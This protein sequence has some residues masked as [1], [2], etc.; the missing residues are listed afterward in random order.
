MHFLERLLSVNS[1]SF[2]CLQGI[3][4]PVKA[5]VTQALWCLSYSLTKDPWC[6]TVCLA[7]TQT[8]PQGL[9]H[10][11]RQW[12]Q[13]EKLDSVHWALQYIGTL[14]IITRSQSSLFMIINCQ[15]A[16]LWIILQ[17]CVIKRQSKRVKCQLKSQAQK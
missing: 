7:F 6:C 4:Q 8:L 16:W 13:K 12:R 5:V 10:T 17:I 9:D 15:Q 2:A 14:C 3:D 1:K 11:I